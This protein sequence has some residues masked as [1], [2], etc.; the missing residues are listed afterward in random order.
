MTP[1]RRLGTST[2]THTSTA[3]VAHRLLSSAMH[4]KDNDW[5]VNSLMVSFHDLRCQSLRR[6]PSTVPCSMLFGSVSWGQTWPNHDNLFLTSDCHT[7]LIKHHPVA[8]VLKSLYSAALQIRC[9]RPAL[10]SIE[11]YGQDEWFVEFILICRKTDGF[12]LPL[13]C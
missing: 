10:T 8:F 12:V 13:Y 4:C 6:L 5:P 1:R 7:Y 2:H 3:M 11:Q 9:Q